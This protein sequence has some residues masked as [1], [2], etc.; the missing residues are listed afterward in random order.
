MIRCSPAWANTGGRKISRA[1]MIIERVN[2]LLIIKNPKNQIYLY[3][4][5]FPE[6]GSSRDR[7]RITHN[8][9]HPVTR[10]KTSSE[11]SPVPRWYPREGL[12][13]RRPPL[14]QLTVPF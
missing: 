9:V 8:L 4:S 5:S 14:G 1:A 12:Y 10:R 11:P 13:P 7:H 3:F 6:F 2:V